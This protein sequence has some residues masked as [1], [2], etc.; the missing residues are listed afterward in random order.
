MKIAPISLL[1]LCVIAP[2]WLFTASPA[3]AGDVSVFTGV[4]GGNFKMPITTLR[5]KRFLTVV[6]QKYDFS[7]GSA[8]VATLLTYHYGRETKE[9]DV[10]RAMFAKG[11]QA[12]IRREGFSLFDMKNY[13]ENLG[14]RADGFR[15][16][17]EKLARVGVPAIVLINLRGY[18]HFVVVKGIENGEVVVGDPAAGVKIYQLPELERIM[19]SDIVF[20]V[21]NH[22]DVGQ[23][24]F[25]GERDWNVRAPAPFGNAMNRDSLGT[26][27]TMPRGPNEF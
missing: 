23:D 12:K 3:S 7:C 25:N 9:E 22:K 15:L 10:F 13:L 17:L 16:P 2:A 21:R 8:A 19:A 18:R 11:D 6:R 20:L 24:G 27:T 5:E 1:V 4:G 26:F 14:Y